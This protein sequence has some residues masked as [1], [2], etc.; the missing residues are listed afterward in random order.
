MV[1]WLRALVAIAEDPGLVLAPT[2]QLTTLH[3]Y[4]SS[5]ASNASSSAQM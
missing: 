4:Y 3:N 5:R 1:Q 2:W